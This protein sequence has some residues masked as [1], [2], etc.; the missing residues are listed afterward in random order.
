MKNTFLLILMIPFFSFAQKQ[1]NVWYF[2]DHGGVDFSTGSPIALANG[3]I[4]Y[5]NGVLHMEGTS[6]ICDSAGKL[7]F[8]TEG[9]NVWNKN[10]Q[11][12]LNGT[13]LLGNYS[14]TQS[15]IIVPD[16]GNPNRYFYLFTIS[17]GFCCNGN[18]S[19]GMRYSKIDICLDN[20]LGDIMPNLKNIKV[21]DTVTEKIAVTKH[22]NGV[23]YWILTHKFYSDQYWALHLTSNGITDTVISAIG[24]IHDGYIGRSQGQMKFS[25][26]G[27]KIAIGGSNG[28]DILEICD[29]NKSTGVVSNSKKIKK[30]NNDKASTYGVEFS[31]DNSK[32]YVHGLTTMGPMYVYF[33]QYDLNAGGGN[34]DSI[35]ASLYR[36]Y[37]DSVGLIAPCGLQI[38]PDDKIYLVSINDQ[39]TLSVVNNPNVQGAGC[40]YQDQ[41]IALAANT[42]GS[43]SLPSFIAGYDYNNGL[44]QC[45]VTEPNNTTSY[46]M[47]QNILI[48][49]NPF[50]DLTTI[51]IPKS[52]QNTTLTL[53]NCFGETIRKIHTG[54]ENV[55]T[56]Y[57]E[58]IAAGLYFLRWADTKNNT[59]AIKLLI[60]D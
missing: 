1:G 55:I 40:N 58:H 27:N 34:I 43:Y 52:V 11:L 17:S 60:V 31:A 35:N 25:N 13:G 10:H 56:L 32:L 38:A 8:Y 46:E 20:T 33:A 2:G 39:T 22:A 3:Q 21:V 5:G 6:A 23:D 4:G 12:M 28:I 14:S 44:T 47:D 16:P 48:S 24:S 29:F 36:I 41:A 42:S 54:S 59:H 51:Q 9:M 49:P 45:D 26:N 30:I 15:S 7:L 18:M 53:I 37:K 57:R 50:S 19:D